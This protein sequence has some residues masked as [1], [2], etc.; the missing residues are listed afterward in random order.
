MKG[1]GH[2]LW[3]PFWNQFDAYCKSVRGILNIPVSYVYREVVEVPENVRWRP[4][5]TVDN[6]YMAQVV[7]TGEHYDEDNSRVYNL[8]EPLV[9]N[10]KAFAFI[11]KFQAA[12][13]GR[14]AIFE[15]RRNATGVSNLDTRKM[16]ANA[17]LKN[18]VYNGKQKSFTFN[19]Y[20]EKANYAYQ[21]LYECQEPEPERRKVAALM[22]NVT[23]ED[24]GSAV[25]HVL[26][27]PNLLHN[28]DKCCEYY[29]NVIVQKTSIKESVGG[30]K[31]SA[32][33]TTTTTSSSRTLKDRYTKEEWTTLPQ[34]TK[35]KVIERNKAKRASG[36]T[37]STTTTPKQNKRKIKSLEA[38]LKKLK[39]DGDGSDG[40]NNN[41]TNSNDVSKS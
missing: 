37:T 23:F 1:T 3:I 9:S 24:S 4:Y 19:N 33:A 39:G 28:F 29:A 13:D 32:T 5:N 34:A 40:S 25:T 17:M 35:D 8:L 27:T 30:R 22:E 2:E 11:Q 41:N 21:E 6:Y 38:Q 20:L 14:G 12:Q 31:I 7:L 16:R 36:G 18:L 10:G 26:G 15:L